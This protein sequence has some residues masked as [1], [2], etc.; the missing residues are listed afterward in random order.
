M[1]NV[2]I[3]T[4]VLIAALTTTMPAQTTGVN[5]EILKQTQLDQLIETI[6]TTDNASTAVSAYAKGQALDRRNSELNNVY[7]RRMLK[8]GLPQIALYPAQVLVFDEPDN[9]LAWAVVGC[10]SGK[11]NDY[12]TALG[13]TARALGLMAKDSQ[14]LNNAG[15]LLAWYD[16]QQVP[17]MLPD[18]AWRVI[19]KSRKGWEASDGYKKGYERIAAVMRDRQ[20]LDKEAADKIAEVQ[21]ACD[22][23]R[24]KL[25]DLE[26]KFQQNDTDLAFHKK[27]LRELRRDFVNSFPTTLPDGTLIGD[28]TGLNRDRILRQ[29][30][31][32]EKAIDNIN[33]DT[34][35]VKRDG[36][37][38]LAAYQ[39]KQAAL[40][41]VR[42]P[43]AKYDLWLQRAFRWEPPAVDGIVTPE[44]DTF[45][46]PKSATTSKPATMTVTAEPTEAQRKME[47]AR[48]YLVNDLPRKA[49][50]ILQEVVTKFPDTPAAQEAHKLLGTISRDDK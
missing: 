49:A 27:L 22:D 15:Q 19:D 35:R 20:R 13:A 26:A 29:I 47:L 31:E 2:A 46:Q 39:E 7:M 34:I 38:A 25:R 9:G 33:A 14:L 10:G 43:A 40:D 24:K 17:P 50:E 4:G 48:L 45:P 42:K 3:L 23:A 8:F 21:K 28:V 32:E 1:R 12:A 41:E 11:K 44:V 30:A 37:E 18:A 36:K 16:A 5:P 6:R